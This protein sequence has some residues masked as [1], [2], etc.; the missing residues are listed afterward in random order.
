MNF[1]LH[2]TECWLEVSTYS[3]RPMT[4]HLHASVIGFSLSSSIC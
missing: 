4:N 1:G 3:A 2:L